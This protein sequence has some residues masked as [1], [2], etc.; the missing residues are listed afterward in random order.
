M[1]HLFL[2]V[3]QTFWYAKV[4]YRDPVRNSNRL[5]L[6]LG[7]SNLR[8]SQAFQAPLLKLVAPTDPTNLT[9]VS[10]RAREAPEIGQKGAL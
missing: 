3:K 9:Y 2:D 1:E 6:P 7:L 4:R 10:G 5:V 8:W